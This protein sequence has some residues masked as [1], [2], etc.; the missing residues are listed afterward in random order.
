M[1]H[2]KLID[3]VY[4][5]NSDNKVVSTYTIYAHGFVYS[6]QRYSDSDFERHH[7]LI[8]QNKLTEIFTQTQYSN[9]CELLNKIQENVNHLEKLTPFEQH[10]KS[11]RDIYKI[12][13]KKTY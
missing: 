1:K 12:E 11:I 13:L 8:R 4:F 3:T 2:L 10:M 7:N 9:F 6:V 5:F